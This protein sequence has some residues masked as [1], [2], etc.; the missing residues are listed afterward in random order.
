VKQRVKTKKLEQGSDF[1]RTG[2]NVRVL[3]TLLGRKTQGPFPKR[4]D[5]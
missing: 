1:V 3:G 5:L 2:C 4:D